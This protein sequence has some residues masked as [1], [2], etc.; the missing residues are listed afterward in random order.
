MSRPN[1]SPQIDHII[2]GAPDLEEGM[3]WVLQH[4]GVRPQRGGR[5]LQQGT[6]NALLG[7]G[8]G[9]YLEVIAPDPES[10]VQGPLWMELH[11]VDRPRLIWWA[12]RVSDLAAY[13]EHAQLQGIGL[14]DLRDGQRSL[15]DGGLL[16]WQMSDPY[17]YDWN[18]LMPFFIEWK[19]RQHPADSLDHGCRLLSLEGR[20][21]Q[22][23]QIGGI[24]RSLQLDVPVAPADTPALMCRI[25]TP[26]GGEWV[27][28]RKG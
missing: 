17:R 28:G 1:T 23:E 27:I 7:L 3:E 5:H 9:C 18:G 15:P 12:A 25:A 22:S 19:S 13:Q 26:R 8:P 11:K 4:I 14:G 2:I 6:H 10:D 21:P 20:H 24:L 16:Q